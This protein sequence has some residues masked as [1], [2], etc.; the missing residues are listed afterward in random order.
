[1]IAPGRGERGVVLAGVLCIAAAVLVLAAAWFEIS[2]AQLR[3]MTGFEQRIRAFHAADAALEACAAMLARQFEIQGVGAE[4]EA[5][6]DV[7]HPFAHWPS[8]AEP[9]VC[10]IEALDNPS[11]PGT[12][13]YL[14]TAHASATDG[15]PPL[16]LQLQ[17]ALASGVVVERRW[18]QLAGQPR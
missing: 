15:S 3:R 18:R 9:P 5:G 1:V 4:A 12:R 14:V 16:W 17:I 10:R 8:L 7:R 11:A 6:D 13:P 2:T